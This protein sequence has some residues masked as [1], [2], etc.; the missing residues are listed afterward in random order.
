VILA[1]DQDPF[2]AKR[3][4]P[5]E[6]SATRGASGLAHTR[7]RGPRRFVVAR[8]SLGCTDREFLILPNS[9]RLLTGTG[10]GKAARPDSFIARIGK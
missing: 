5:I 10:Q 2:T 7:A 8:Q 1:H 4:R 3:I 9:Q 6:R